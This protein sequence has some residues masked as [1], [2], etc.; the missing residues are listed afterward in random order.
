VKDLDTENY[1]TLM[2]EITNKC[3]GIHCSWTG[4]FSIAKMSVLPKTIYRF[5]IILISIPMVLFPDREQNPKIYME[6]QRISNR[7]TILRKKNKAGGLT[8]LDCE[9]YYKAIVVKIIWCWH[10]DKHKTIEINSQIN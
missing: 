5:S 8:L 10:E 7:K 1:K 9:I 2:K 4:R 3:K 6:P